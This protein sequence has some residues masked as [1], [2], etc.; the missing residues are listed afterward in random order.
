MRR[1]IAILALIAWPLLALSPRAEDLSPYQALLTPL[2]QSGQTV[3]GQPLQYPAGDP[4][5]T[6][7]IVTLPPGGETGWHSHE[8]PLFGYVL[9]GELTVD[10]GSKGVKLYKAGDSW[11]EAM[12]WPHNGMNKGQVPV[13]LIAVYMGGGDKANTVKSPAP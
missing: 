4:K 12:N 10:Y 1:H 2:L 3:L 6:G 9:E 8:V 11:L 7:A 13:K 5:V